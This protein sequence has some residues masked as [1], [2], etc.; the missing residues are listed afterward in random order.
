MAINM[1]KKSPNTSPESSSDS[2][3]AVS[4]YNVAQDTE[5][6]KQS[7]VGS[8]IIEDLTASLDIDNLETIA[9][10]GSDV[11]NEIAKVSDSVLNSMSLNKINESSA[12]LVTLSTIMDQFDLDEITD[13]NQNFFTKLLNNSKKK[14][15]QVLSKYQTI[16]GEVDKIY[17]ELKSY[18]KEI[19]QSNMHLEQIF[20]T[21]VAYYHNL[22]EYIV[23]GEQGVQEI[24]AYIA[25]RKAEYDLTGDASIS[26]EIQHL[27]Q[28]SQILQDRTYDLRIAESVAIQSIPMLK[29]MQFSN[30]NLVRKINS[31]FIITLPIFKQA[32]AQAIMLK[33]QRIQADAMDAL[34]KKTNEMLLRN[35]QNTV[36]QAQ[37]I[38]KLTSTNSVKIDTLEQTWNTIKNGIEETKQI[39]EKAL[40]E[41]EQDIQRLNTLKV[42]Y[43]NSFRR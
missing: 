2:E 13:D 22:L 30:L 43:K 33:R 27:E 17:I 20:K 41:R 5:K 9:S 7:L 18:E 10:F 36:T 25:E 40:Q 6:F 21:N 1:G 23:A 8:Q 3:F 24:T 31:A 37:M 35:A 38:A 4:E 12:M 19:H 32:L 29:T 26:F 34:D 14:L 42:D 16:G 15:D 28:A 39:Q 11:A